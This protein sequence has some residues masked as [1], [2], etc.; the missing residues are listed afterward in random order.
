MAI[1]FFNDIPREIRDKIYRFALPSC[2]VE[3]MFMQ[4][5][6]FPNCYS[7]V[8]FDV[9]ERKAGD[10][11][12][13]PSIS[14]LLASKQVNK[15]VKDIFWR[16]GSKIFLYDFQAYRPLQHVSIEF[17][18]QVEKVVVSTSFP[19]GHDGDN[20]WNLL[21]KLENW[22]YSGALKELVLVPPYW[23]SDIGNVRDSL[24]AHE[25]PEVMRRLRIAA[26][27]P[28][29]S[30]VKKSFLVQDNWIS[31]YWINPNT[32]NLDKKREDMHNFHMAFGAELEMDGVLCCEDGGCKAQ[33][34]P[35]QPTT[36]RR[37]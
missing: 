17:L 29:H 14:L 21:R 5:G 18:H 15:E 28:G 4:R 9:A 20:I 19:P 27:W 35:N 30:K 11:I 32:I 34:S 1:N 36:A 6:F 7:P 13:F 37:R 10:R 8:S 24:F 23:K 22:A 16:N 25:D 2:D 12:I 26:A 3:C 33:C 31:W